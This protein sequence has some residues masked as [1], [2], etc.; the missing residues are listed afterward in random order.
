LPA[1]DPI[2][3]EICE[4]KILVIVID[5]DNVTKEDSAILLESFNNGQELQFDNSVA[6]VSIGKFATVECQG[7]SILLDY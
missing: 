1:A 3:I 6:S 2:S 7:S 5:L 4:G